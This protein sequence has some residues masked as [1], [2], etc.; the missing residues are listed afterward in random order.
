[1][2]VSILFF[3]VGLIPDLA[4][5]RD[6]APERWRR[7]LY[8][9]AALGW[10]GSSRHWRTHRYASRMLAGIATPLV[11]SVHTVISFD[12]AIAITPG[13]HTTIF[14]PFFVI[15]ALHSGFALVLVLLVLLRTARPPFAT[16]V[17]PRHL[18]ALAKLLLTTGMLMAYSYGAEMFTSWYTREPAEVYTGVTSRLVGPDAVFFW[19]MIATNCVA[20]MLLWSPALRRSPPVLT[21]VGLLVL[22]GMWLERFV[23][24][25]R[26][27]SHDYLPSSWGTYVPTPVDAAIL[28]GTM[29]FFTLLFLLFVQYVPPVPVAEVKALAH[30]EEHP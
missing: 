16:V 24:I 5:A 10:R 26:A 25:V 1:V 8:G 29:S 2:T 17:T 6:R 15:G 22:L 27:Q 23:I 28:I 21:I 14:P 18:D 30:E 12:F 4:T 11:V 3:Y 7:R 20:P 13:W 9:L 19:A